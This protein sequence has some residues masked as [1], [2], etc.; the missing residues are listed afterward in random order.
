LLLAALRL[1]LL[2]GRLRTRLPNRLL[3]L[4]LRGPLLRLRRLR[5]LQLCGFGLPLRLLSGLRVLL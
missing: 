4:G 5:V 3:L 1:L 2:H